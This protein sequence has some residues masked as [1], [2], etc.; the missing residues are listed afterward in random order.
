MGTKQL[1]ARL[2]QLDIDASRRAFTS[3]ATGMISAGI[4]AH[5]WIE[6]R[7][8]PKDEQ[9]EIFVWLAAIELWTRYLPDRCCAERLD[10]FIESAYQAWDQGRRKKACDRWWQAWTVI[11]RLIDPRSSHLYE[12]D[13]DLLLERDLLHLLPEIAERHAMTGDPAYAARGVE[14]CA[15]AV[16][17][18][19]DED[20][21]FILHMRALHAHCLYCAGQ[22][23]EDLEEFVA[24][25]PSR[26]DL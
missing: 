15:Y 9:T 25:T 18:F 2:A 14:L 22:A 6:H 20:I 4:I 26:T 8:R 12:A 19:E 21:G 7:A 3:R 16:E 24:T 10:E 17:Q 23:D 11:R 5:H 13:E 1:V